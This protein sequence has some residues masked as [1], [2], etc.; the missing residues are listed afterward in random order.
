[1]WARR[2]DVCARGELQ[3]RGS[4]G[5]VEH[6]TGVTGMVGEAGD[7]GQ[8]E[9]NRVVPSS[10]QKTPQGGPINVASDTQLIVGRHGL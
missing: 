2:L 1:M 9:G 10:W 7:L 5:Q 3:V 8:A 6:H 4:P